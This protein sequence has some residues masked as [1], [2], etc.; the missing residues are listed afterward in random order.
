MDKLNQ[1][2]RLQWKKTDTFVYYLEPTLKSKFLGLDLDDTL[3]KVKSNRKFALDEKDWIFWHAN[4]VS[5]I[6][7]YA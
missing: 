6:Q 5:R 1:T 4:V 7:E 3:I 2:I